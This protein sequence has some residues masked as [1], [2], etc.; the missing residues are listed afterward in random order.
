MDNQR[1]QNIWSKFDSWVNEYGSVQPELL[2]D[3]QCELLNMQEEI[4]AWMRYVIKLKG[5]LAD[6]KNNQKPKTSVSVL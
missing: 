3:V 6:C 5:E 4:D 1:R 2:M